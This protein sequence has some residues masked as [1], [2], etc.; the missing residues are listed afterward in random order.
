M[1]LKN[2]VATN[3][4]IKQEIQDDCQF[5]HHSAKVLDMPNEDDEAAS[6]N[7]IIKG[8]HF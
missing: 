4:F 2:S 3:Q 7:K 5:E 1:T 6:E 8:N